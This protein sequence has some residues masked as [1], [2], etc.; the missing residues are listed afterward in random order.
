MIQEIAPFTLKAKVYQFGKRWIF[1]PQNGY[2]SPD[3][4]RM[5]NEFTFATDWH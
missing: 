5:L 4:N 3:G 2:I 1:F